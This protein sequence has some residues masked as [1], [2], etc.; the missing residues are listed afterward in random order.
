M[1]LRV[2]KVEFMF[3]MNYQDNFTFYVL[4]MEIT[5]ALKRFKFAT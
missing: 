3:G 4:W 1:Q 2:N 5:F